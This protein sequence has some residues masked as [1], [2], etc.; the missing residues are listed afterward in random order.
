LIVRGPSLSLRYAT[1]ADAPALLELG[2]DPEVTRFFSWGPYEDVSEPVDYVHSLARQRE[3]G[4]RLE[5]VIVDGDDRPIGVTGLSEFAHRDRRAIVGTW[6]GRAHW[7]TGANRDSKALI[8]S[9]AFRTLGLLRAT[10]LA[11]PE[12]VRSIAALEKLGFV[13]E[14]VLRGWHIHDGVPRDCAMLRLMRGDFE[15]GPLAGVPVEVEGEAPPQFVLRGASG[16]A[17]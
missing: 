3:A 1:E 17:F 5:F 9:L 4:E 11:S 6:L 13:S 7:G 10:A 8:L 14:G 2:S 15:A 12:N 16:P